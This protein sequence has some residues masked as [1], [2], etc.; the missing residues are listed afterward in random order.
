MMGE[1]G[2]GGVF[3]VFW[4][5]EL[6]C[7]VFLKIYCLLFVYLLSAQSFQNVGY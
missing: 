3:S 4:K 6:P 7:S 2:V 1:G 5:Y